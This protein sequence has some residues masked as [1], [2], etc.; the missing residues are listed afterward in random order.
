M[1]KINHKMQIVDIL[2]PSCERILGGLFKSEDGCI[3][4]RKNLPI[5]ALT[6]SEWGEVDRILGEINL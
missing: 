3:Y 6:D 4:F 2:N 5:E 1:I